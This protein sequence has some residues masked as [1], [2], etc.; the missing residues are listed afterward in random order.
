MRLLSR[1]T[2]E[3]REALSNTYREP[4]NALVSHVTDGSMRMGPTMPPLL[5][6]LPRLPRSDH[7]PRWERWLADDVC[8][9][10]CACAQA[11][12]LQADPDGC[13]QGGCCGRSHGHRL[14]RGDLGTCARLACRIT[15]GRH[16][17]RS[18]HAGD[19]P[20]G[21]WPGRL[22]HPVV[23][24]AGSGSRDDLGAAGYDRCGQHRAHHLLQDCAPAHPGRLACIH[25]ELV[26]SP[27]INSLASIVPLSWTDWCVYPKL[28]N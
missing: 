23:C 9:C 15:R 27:G 25:A 11:G 28:I 5:T 14:G 12:Q 2:R 24:K 3:I 26:I 6:P 16:R 4:L 20:M 19:I 8:N 13:R 22:P 17:G 18:L 10:A 21:K 7:G 1:R